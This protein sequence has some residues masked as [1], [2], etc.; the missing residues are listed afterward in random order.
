MRWVEIRYKCGCLI[1]EVTFLMPERKDGE[2]VA[3]FMDRMRSALFNDHR[4][5]SP[6][7][8]ARKTEYVKVPVPGDVVGGAEGGQA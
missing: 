8:S 3:V 6:R 7:C 2:D 4:V 5:K 1:E